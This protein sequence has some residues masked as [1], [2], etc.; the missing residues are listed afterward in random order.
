M[1]SSYQQGVWIRTIKA[2]L[3]TFLR[4]GVWSPA[5]FLLLTVFSPAVLS[6]V[7]SACSTLAALEQGGVEPPVPCPWFCWDTVNYLE[8]TRKGTAALF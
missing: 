3:L 8:L 2:S 5:V 4:L 6:A 7:D 1:E